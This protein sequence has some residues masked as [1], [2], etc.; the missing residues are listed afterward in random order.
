MYVLL[1]IS[2]MLA[3]ENNYDSLLY[4]LSINDYFTCFNFLIHSERINKLYLL[5][6]CKR[7]FVIYPMVHFYYIHPALKFYL[8]SNFFSL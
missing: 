6:R 7:S 3:A 2:L 8:T 5:S 1:T 4:V